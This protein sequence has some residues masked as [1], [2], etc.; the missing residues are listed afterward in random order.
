MGRAFEVRKVAM[1]KSAAVKSKLYAKYGR[2]IYLAAKSGTPDPDTNQTLK[3]MIE[4][5]KK[6]QV[7]ADVIKRNIDKA[8]GGGDDNLSSIR[9]EGFG[10]GN[11]MFIVE[12]LTDNVNRTISEV[13]NC[14]TKTGGKLGISGS[15]VHQFNHQAVFAMK[16]ITE[17][18][19]LEILVEHD[20]D[21][22]DIE[23]DDEGVTIYSD[24]TNFN[25]IR[26]AFNEAKP[27]LDYD[28]E[29]IMWLPIM[30]ATL[31]NEEDQEKFERLTNM[32]DELDDV[33]DVYHNVSL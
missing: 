24:A 18:E 4:K 33:Q 26:T 3:R 17:D 1:A 22:S 15:V 27:D 10:P 9:Y 12:C 11:S 28:T 30:E 25:A 23:S 21:V 2:E 31:D 32:L 6:E 19:V 16:D 8:K 5:A 29:E 13:R 14:F 20:L 7:P